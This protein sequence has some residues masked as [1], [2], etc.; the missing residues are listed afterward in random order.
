MLWH[1]SRHRT[2][3]DITQGCFILWRERWTREAA[4]QGLGS[5]ANGLPRCHFIHW[6]S[7]TCG[8]APVSPGKWSLAR[9][10]SQPF[11]PSSSFSLPTYIGPGHFQPCV[12]NNCLYV[13]LSHSLYVP[14]GRGQRLISFISHIRCS[15]KIITTKWHL[16]STY[17]ML[18]TLLT[19]SHLM[20]TT[21][22]YD[23]KGHG[24]WSQTTWV[25]SLA[26]L[27]SAKCPRNRW[28]S[29]ADLLT[30]SLNPI[31]PS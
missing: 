6:F 22:Q 11:F 31:L 25:Q 26:P 3:L 12:E 23:G 18:D 8:S 28:D 9:P 7:G 14:G 19:S 21:L 1:R 2:G 13:C 27:T 10:S 24:F 30:C 17:C 4:K 29:N 16:L 15:V 5:W 20:L